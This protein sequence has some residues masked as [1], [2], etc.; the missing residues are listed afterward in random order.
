MTG[1]FALNALEL[2]VNAYGQP[3]SLP[4]PF[5]YEQQAPS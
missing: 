1:N 4:Q 2:Q 3:G 5:F